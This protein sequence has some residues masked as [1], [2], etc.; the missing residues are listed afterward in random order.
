LGWLLFNELAGGF[1]FR[2]INFIKF[3]ELGVYRVSIEEG[4]V[5]FHISQ[6]HVSKE[7]HRVLR[8]VPSSE[9]IEVSERRT[10]ILDACVWFGDVERPD[11]LPIVYELHLL[12]VAL[13][14]TREVSCVV[15]HAPV[16]KGIVSDADASCCL[17]LSHLGLVNI[18]VQIVNYEVDGDATFGGISQFLHGDLRYHFVIHIV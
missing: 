14:K 8:V 2:R 17:E 1:V 18:E 4:G 5:V 7:L 16:G 3:V 12:V 15:V 9:H 6:Q 10:S 11:E 13:E